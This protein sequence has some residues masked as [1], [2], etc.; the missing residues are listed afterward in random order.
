M[1]EA[2]VIDTNVLEHVFDAARNADGHLERLLRKFAEQK[3]KL[4]LDR[5]VAGGQSRIMGEYNHRLQFHLK[6]IHE[7]GHIAQWLRY[8]LLLAERVD[9]PVN[10]SD[11][12]GTRVAA[13]MNRVRAERSDQVFVYIACVLDSV[14]VSNNSRHVTDLRRALRRCARS[15]G[16]DNTD[17]LSS[18]QAEAAM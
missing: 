14:M 6:A 7:Q 5:P 13:Q 16:S 15:V 1:T 12:L 4:C 8:L 3:R 18:P 11:A 10:L 2:M 9:A 17:F